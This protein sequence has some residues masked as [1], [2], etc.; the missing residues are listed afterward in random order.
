M[1]SFR[2]TCPHLDRF[3]GIRCFMTGKMA[4]KTVW[5]SILIIYRQQNNMYNEKNSF[6]GSGDEN[7]QDENVKRTVIINDF[8][9][10]RFIGGKVLLTPGVKCLDDVILGKVMNAVQQFDDFTG[11]NDPYG[12]HDFGMFKIEG[13]RYFWK[14]D[15]YDSAFE[16]H[17]L[18][19][20]NPDV[21]QRVLTIMTAD[22]Y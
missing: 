1:D 4:S 7:Q 3:Q 22:E 6:N 20:S 14:I 17:S 21:T 12:E 13:I 16:T 11:D 10:K 9:R 15:Y 5:L 18:D 19:K 2:S 8:L